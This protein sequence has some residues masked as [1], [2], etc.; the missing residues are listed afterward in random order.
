VS[1]QA[2]PPTLC[3]N[4]VSSSPFARCLLHLSAE[5]FLQPRGCNQLAKKITLCY[6]LAS[7]KKIPPLLL[8]STRDFLNHLNCPA[9]HPRPIKR[10]VRDP[11]IHYYARELKLNSIVG[12]HVPCR[13]SMMPLVVRRC[14]TWTVIQAASLLDALLLFWE[15]AGWSME[16]CLIVRPLRRVIPCVAKGQGIP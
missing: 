10:Q 12:P 6:P 8:I 1:S 3:G 14:A 5:C 11:R 15:A 9:S 13:L 4:G 16:T 2:P 7:T